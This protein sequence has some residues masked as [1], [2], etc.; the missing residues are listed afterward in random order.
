MGE[1]NVIQQRNK[2]TIINLASSLIT[3]VVS[4]AI[5]FFLSPFIV[6]TFGEEANGFTQLA[7]N[8]ITYASLLTVALNSMASRFIT[9][10]YYKG[11][12]DK[13]N[14][15]YSSVIIANIAIMLF[16][17]FPAIICIYKLEAIIN[18]SSE[19][20]FQVK[21]L[22]SFVFAT[23]YVSQITG[24]L[25]VATYVKNCLYLQNIINMV[26]TITKAVLLI[27]CFSLL[28]PKMYYVSCVGFI[29]TVFTIPVSYSIK[30]KIFNEVKF[31]VK[32][33]NFKSVKTLIGSG[34]W[35]TVNQCGN[36]LMTGLDLL[37]SN[38]FL[39]P[40]QMGVLSV[41]KTIP[42]S[43][44]QVASTINTS[45]SPNQTIAYSSDE[46]KAFLNSLKYSTTVSCVLLSVLIMVFCVFAY[47]FYVLWQPTLNAKTLAIL[48]ILTCMVFIPFCGTQTLYNVYTSANKL[49][50]NSVSFII[51]G[52]LNF[53]VVFILLKCTDLDLYAVAGVSSILS[54]CR[55]GMITIPYIAKILKVK[56]YYFYK[57]VGKSLFCCLIVGIVSFAVRIIIYPSSW[58]SLII[59]VGIAAILSLCLNIFIVLNKEQ[60]E[61]LLLKLR[62]KNRG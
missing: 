12:I 9:I 2:Q 36:I 44:T 10:H 39:G 13:C 29:L 25:N 21:I 16:L 41:A 22:F 1:Q 32:D 42:T 27:L 34:I 59:A 58:I 19:N 14:Q 8:F 20:V 53:V 5:N 46:N 6:R 24:I 28:I 57:D 52:L 43:I 61:Q 48:S 3:L 26:R 38:L 4:L 62:R 51:T 50:V 11:E 40:V 35:N 7:N 15:Y 55:N 54:M 45:F 33:F 18:I 37:L 23:F 31:S 49:A 56:W 47:D 17:L 60:R 30:R